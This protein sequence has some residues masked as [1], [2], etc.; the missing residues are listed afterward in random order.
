MSFGSSCFSSGTSECVGG[1]LCPVGKVCSPR[2]NECVLP[3]QLTECKPPKVDGDAC[4][5][6]GSAGICLGGVCQ[7]PVTGCGNGVLDPDEECDNGD[8]IAGDGCSPF[9]K[10]ERC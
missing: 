10:L 8:T 7:L 9:C 2:A 3:D 1:F 5:V 6:A 4:A